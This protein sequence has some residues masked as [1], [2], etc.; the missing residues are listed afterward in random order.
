MNSPTTIDHD[1]ESD[2]IL[3]KFPEH[4]RRCDNSVD[5][6][7]TCDGP[8]DG[9]RVH[10]SW[11]TN[12]K[13]DSELCEILIAGVSKIP[14]PRVTICGHILMTNAEVDAERYDQAMKRQD[15]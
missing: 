3:I 6:I 14:H 7:E 5:V 2:T 12:E 8:V 9:I 11:G 13:F 15:T 4:I 1:Q 10:L